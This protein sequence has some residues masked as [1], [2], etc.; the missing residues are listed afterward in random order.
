MPFTPCWTIRGW[1]KARE[2][3]SLAFL[4]S[5]GA[6]KNGLVLRE[7]GFNSRPPAKAQGPERGL[8]QRRVR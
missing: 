3:L 8:A 7:A 2:A 4:P 5:L 6:P 1:G